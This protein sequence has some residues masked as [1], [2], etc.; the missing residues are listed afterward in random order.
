[1]IITKE[2]IEQVHAHCIEQVIVND[3]YTHIANTLLDR[4]GQPETPKDIVLFWQHYWEALPDS[5][6]I[7]RPPFGL[8]C[9]IAENIFNEEF[10]GD[11]DERST[12]EDLG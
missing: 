10:M 5:R 6:A 1:M 8:I 12:E 7:Q 4:D 2:N 9:D 3:Y 11:E